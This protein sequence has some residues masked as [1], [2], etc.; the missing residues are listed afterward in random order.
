MRFTVDYPDRP[1]NRLTTFF[2][3][4]TVIPIAILLAAVSGGTYSFD[5][6]GANDA[7]STFA[8][9]GGFLF[10]APLLMILFREKYPLWCASRTGSA[11][12]G[13]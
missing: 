4:F 7:S 9:A 6:G 8:A 2:R 5:W 13:G 3:A 10:L 1:L 11:S 12:T